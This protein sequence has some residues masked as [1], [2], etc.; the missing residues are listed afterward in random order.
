MGP[1]HR[2]GEVLEQEAGLSSPISER[3]GS[4]IVLSGGQSS[5]T[6]LPW[7]PSPVRQYRLRELA[8]FGLFVET[9]WR[10]WR[11]QSPV[12]VNT[13][14]SICSSGIQEKR[15]KH[16]ILSSGSESTI[17]VPVP[18]WFSPEETVSSLFIYTPMSD[19]SSYRGPLYLE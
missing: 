17:S 14:L 3:E 10:W 12:I 19:L 13:S 1:S 5:V 15:Y 11:P 4:I 9:G 2:K 7:S 8:L 18:Q 6:Y 16:I